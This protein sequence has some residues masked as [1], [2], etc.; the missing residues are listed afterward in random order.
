[1]S[2]KSFGCYLF[3]CD[4]S[5]TFLRVT[6]RGW[7]ASLRVTTKIGQL[8]QELARTNPWWSDPNWQYL[9]PDLPGSTSRGMVYESHVL[10]GLEPSCLYILKGP[11]SAGKTVAV[12][13]QILNLVSSGTPP[14][15]IIRI[16]A[17]GMDA[18]DIRTVVQ[19]TALPLAPE[20]QRA[21]I[22]IGSSTR[23]LPSPV[24]GMSK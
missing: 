10:A 12:K 16:A 24:N 11:R 18:K 23:F 4:P 6:P 21:R 15:S 9:D 13:Q 22:D 2:V 1:M 7:G 14:T 8:A 19:R 20:G 3:C 5:S 17:G